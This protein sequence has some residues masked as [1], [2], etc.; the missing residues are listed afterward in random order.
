MNLLR[1]TAQHPF[2]YKNDTKGA[3]NRVVFE[4]EASGGGSKAGGLPTLPFPSPP[5]F[6]SLTFQTNQWE[7]RSDPVTGKFPGFPPTNT[8]LVRNNCGGTTPQA[9]GPRAGGRVLEKSSTTTPHQLGRQRSAV[10]FQ[11]QDPADKC[12]SYIVRPLDCSLGAND[13]LLL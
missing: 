13:K 12:L 8:T 5:P 4:A 10:R 3:R 1:L 2:S 6:H 7:E 9:Q 11:V